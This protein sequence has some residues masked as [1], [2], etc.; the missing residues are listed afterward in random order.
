MGGIKVGG[1]IC[2]GIETI[3]NIRGM[4]D[5]ML[6]SIEE[7]Y[8]IVYAANFWRFYYMIFHNGMCGPLINGFGWMFL[9]NT[10]FAFVGLPIYACLA[11][12]SLTTLSAMRVADGKDIDSDSDPSDSLE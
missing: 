11:R 1:K 12:R 4:L 8:T 2:S 5:K 9:F 7:L 10:G 3:L 6:F